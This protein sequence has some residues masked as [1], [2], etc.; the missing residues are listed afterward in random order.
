MVCLYCG[1]D[2]E[3]TNSRKQKR[4]NQVWRRRRCY[5]CKSLF[6]THEA[7]DF[8]LSLLVEVRGLPGPFVPDR[9]YTDVLMALSDRPDCYVAAKEVTSTV[10]NGLLELPQSPLFLPPQI[11]LMTAKV[12]KRLDKRAHLRYTAE[13]PSLQ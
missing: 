1:G 13:H 2:T 4:N 11:S 10:I 7:I 8:G 3:V 9:L 12:L 5:R 6:T